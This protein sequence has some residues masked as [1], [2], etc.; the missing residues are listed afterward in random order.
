MKNF[1]NY[2]HTSIKVNIPLDSQELNFNFESCYSEV[3]EEIDTLLRKER[4]KIKLYTKP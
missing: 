4:I 2:K 3:L 1:E